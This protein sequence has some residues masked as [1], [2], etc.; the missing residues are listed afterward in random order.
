V[1]HDVEQGVLHLHDE[2]NA[3]QQHKAHQERKRQAQNA[4]LVAL[5]RRQFISKDG[6]KDQVINPENNLEQDKCQ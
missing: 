6:D 5:V 4:G 3:C 2:G 1:I